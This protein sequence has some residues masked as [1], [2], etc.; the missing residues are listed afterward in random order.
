MSNQPL[1]DSE[2]LQLIFKDIGLNVWEWDIEAN[3]VTFSAPWS[4]TLGYD[5]HEIETL[6]FSWE[7]L[8]HPDDWPS[9]Q[10]ALAAHLNNETSLFQ[11][12]YRLHTKSGEW[13][14][15]LGS[16]KVTVR[17]EKGEVRYMGGTHQQLEPLKPTKQPGQNDKV[18]YQVSEKQ[19]RLSHLLEDKT[20]GPNDAQVELVR[21]LRLK[22]GFM[23]NMS[24]EL[25]TPLNA[26]IGISDIL[27]EDTYGPLNDEQKNSIEIIKNSGQHLLSLINDILDLSKINAGQSELS[28]S[29]VDVIAVCKSII[30]MVNPLAKNKSIKLYTS[31]EEDVRMINA[32]EQRLAQALVNLLSNAIKFTPD[33]GKVGLDIELD[34]K[35]K[36]VQ[37]SVW[38]TGVGIAEEN[39]DNLFEPFAQ[40]GD[41]YTRNDAGTGLGLS[42]VKRIA[43]M[44]G[45][46][47]AVESKI[48]FGSRFTLS[49]PY[50][51]TASST[52]TNQPHASSEN[53]TRSYSHIKKVLIIEDSATDAEQIKHY[54]GQLGVSS[55]IISGMPDSYSDI[56]KH[57][58]DVQPDL[59]F[60]DII[61][62]G[63][64]GWTTLSQLKT[65]KKTKN[66]PV[67]ICSVL[68]QRKRAMELGAAEYLIKPVSKTD[69]EQ[70]MNQVSPLDGETLQGTHEEDDDEQPL[71]LL[72]EDDETNIKIVS[73][74]LIAYGYRVFVAR[75]GQEAIK[76]VIDDQPDLVLMDIQMPVMDGLEAIRR[77]R[78]NKSKAI[79]MTP[80]VA[81]TALAMQ[82]DSARCLE[83]GADDYISKPISLKEL[84]DRIEKILT[85]K[86][87]APIF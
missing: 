70:V 50:I 41:D 8:I 34:S 52:D 75:H 2:R 6:S 37:L 76:R 30:H 51:D 60:L 61:M 19:R 21:S 7:Q 39:I 43:E 10:S 65:D 86:M 40:A 73:D 68:H 67:I 18:L 45:G 22:D 77:I 27:I 11:T 56:T 71:I 16:G 24:H 74:Y 84:S 23:A 12:E 85:A 64:S 53:L 5:S 9:V 83:A 47:I 13:V 26:V 38:D 25:R 4:A 54:L 35:Q 33:Y 80:I 58:R 14:R 69:I 31:F 82:G 36:R 62:P 17:D 59:I 44:H 1:Q 63:Q 57:V 42:L 3:S 78:K 28:V 46:T 55:I 81:V 48:G 15:T 29:K 66:I 32:N 20:T 49:L 72:V 87:L 79:R